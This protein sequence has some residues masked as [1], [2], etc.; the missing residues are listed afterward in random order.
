MFLQNNPLTDDGFV[1]FSLL[2]PSLSLHQWN[3]IT[4]VVSSLY[5]E[6]ANLAKTD[7]ESVDVEAMKAI[8]DTSINESCKY[9]SIKTSYYYSIG[10]K[11]IYA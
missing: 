6:Q 11:Q 5:K 2:Q 8:L 10:M 3:N 1:D 9:V 4:D 7:N